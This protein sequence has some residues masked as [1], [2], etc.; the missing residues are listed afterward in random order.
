MRVMINIKLWV[1]KPSERHVVHRDLSYHFTN[2][3]ML[4]ESFEMND[5]EKFCTSYEVKRE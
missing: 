3:E 1:G 5:I 4:K 2:V